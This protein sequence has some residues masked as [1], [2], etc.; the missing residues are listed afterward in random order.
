MTGEV[1]LRDTSDTKKYLPLWMMKRDSY[2]E[3]ALKLG[4]EVKFNNRSHASSNWIGKGPEPKRGII[5]YTRFLQYWNENHGHVVVSLPS[6]DICSLCHALSNQ[7]RY[8]LSHDLLFCEETDEVKEGG[9]ATDSIAYDCDDN[10]QP[11][12]VCDPPDWDSDDETSGVMVQKQ[13]LQATPIMS[14]PAYM[15]LKQGNRCCYKQHG[16]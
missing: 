13:Q 1:S 7:H 3:Y 9:D 6:K 11:S 12:L 8:N 16:M 5:S 2:K 10:V 15:K 14:L 4:Y